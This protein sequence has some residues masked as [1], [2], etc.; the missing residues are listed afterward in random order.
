MRLIILNRH[1]Y[2]V[3]LSVI[4]LLFSTNATA[5]FEKA[6]EIYSQGNFKEAKSAFE[7]MAAVGD[8]SSL[9]NLGVMYYRGEAVEHD[10][11]KA[12]ALM[13]IA[14]EGSSEESLLKIMN[15]VFSRLSDEDRQRSESL[16]DELKLTYSTESIQENIIPKLLDDEDCTPEMV[17]L[18][19]QLPV[20]PHS[21]FQQG[22]MGVVHVDFMVSPEGYTRELAVTASTNRLFT[23]SALNAVEK[24][25]YEPIN[26]REARGERLA[27]IYKIDVGLGA[28]VAS[29]PLIRE[30]NGYKDKALTGDPVAQ[31][32]FARGLN[33][34]RQ[35]KD[36][37]P[38]HRFQYRD[39]NEWF[40]RSAQ[41]GVVNAQ[42]EIGLNM[43]KGRGCEVDKENGF[44][45]IQA[46]AI[47]GYSRAQRYLAT[48]ELNNTS[49]A[50]DSVGSVFSLLKNAARD[51]IYGF[52]AK[53]MLAWE[54][55][56]S[57]EKSMWNPAEALRLISDVPNT[58]RDDLRLL[59]TKAAAYAVKGDF[60]KARKFQKKALKKMKE[61]KWDIQKVKERS[62][63]Y[64][65]GKIYAGSYY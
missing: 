26:N 2:Y 27:L 51:E 53:A 10:S 35:F 43:M 14:N 30:L 52:P 29:R 58:Y 55:V 28:R 31:F 18:H 3:A 24:H 25:I 23:K 40:T 39:A 1:S 63:L 44:K 41:S 15:A 45:W 9:F 59:E 13:R 4:A 49:E 20:Y 47:G 42:F 7:V 17:P 61:N 62:N 6:L 37:L 8:T 57:P 21:E 65:Q 50:G 16:Y 60:K 33:T 32:M 56:A 22:R 48:S 54:L 11:A 64:N 19:R 5:S 36:L 46:A 12:Y 34:Y 38:E